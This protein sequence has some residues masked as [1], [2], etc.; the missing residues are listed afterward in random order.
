M[1]LALHRGRP[2]DTCSG[3]LTAALGRAYGRPCTSDGNASRSRTVVLAN[4][5]GR[6]MAVPIRHSTGSGTGSVD[7]FRGGMSVAI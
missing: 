2:T 6:L 4:A 1:Q 3:W 7:V 5:D